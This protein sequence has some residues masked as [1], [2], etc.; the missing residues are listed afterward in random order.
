MPIFLVIYDSLKFKKLKK[1]VMNEFL[2]KGIE[3]E[4][5]ISNG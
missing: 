3:H 5:K 4:T 1:N 2:S